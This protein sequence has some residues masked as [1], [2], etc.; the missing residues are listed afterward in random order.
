[1]QPHVARIFRTI[2]LQRINV[3]K[4]VKLFL[5]GKNIYIPAAKLLETVLSYSSHYYAFIMRYME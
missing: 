2:L 4:S 3:G 1:M 5:K